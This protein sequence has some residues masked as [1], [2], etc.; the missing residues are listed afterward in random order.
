VR[1]CAAALAS[2]LKM[3]PALQPPGSTAS[4]PWSLSRYLRRPLARFGVEDL[5]CPLP[6]SDAW[7]ARAGRLARH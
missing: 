6:G 4:A 7:Q 5:C 3:T 1:I 2:A